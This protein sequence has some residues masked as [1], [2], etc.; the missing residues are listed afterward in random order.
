MRVQVRCH[1]RRETKVEIKVD[2]VV[3]VY[4]ATGGVATEADLAGWVA[5][6]TRIATAVGSIEDPAAGQ[7]A[8]T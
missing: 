1:P 3:H 4:P 6:L 5:R 8:N 7:A 2:V